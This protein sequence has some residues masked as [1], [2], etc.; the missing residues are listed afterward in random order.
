MPPN[1]VTLNHRLIENL[2]YKH[3]SK[4]CPINRKYASK[5]C[6]CQI[7]IYPKPIINNSRAAYNNMTTV[8][9]K[10]WLY[11]LIRQDTYYSSNDFIIFT[12]TIIIFIVILALI[13]FTLSLSHLFLI[14]TT[15]LQ[16]ADNELFLVLSHE[17]SFV[18]LMCPHCGLC[19]PVVLQQ[20]LHFPTQLLA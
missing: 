3:A 15:T 7:S 1:L 16:S 13:N 18:C 14:S 11:N 10:T 19:Q 17:V 5:I 6:T 2:L 12:I 8:N 20:R 4:P 9:F